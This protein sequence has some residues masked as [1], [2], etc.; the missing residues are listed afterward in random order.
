MKLRA[1][2]FAAAFTTDD[3]DQR[4]GN[5]ARWRRCSGR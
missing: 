4:A 2:V 1:L 5:A 3:V